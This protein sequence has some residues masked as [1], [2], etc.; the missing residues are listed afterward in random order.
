MFFF[1]VVRHAFSLYQI[2]KASAPTTQSVAAQKEAE[3]ELKS[4]T[5][6]LMETA[7][8]RFLILSIVS[9]FFKISCHRLAVLFYSLR[10]MNKGVWLCFLRCM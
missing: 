8:S 9:Q 1:V 10:T 2:P 7:V 3:E 5:P 4:A 6:Q